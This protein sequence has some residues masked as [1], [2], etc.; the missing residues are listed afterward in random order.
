[1]AGTGPAIDWL[2]ESVTD[3]D[4]GDVGALQRPAYR[5]GLIAIEAGEAGPE[6]LPFALGD[7]RLG[8]RIG[9][10]K[11]TAGLAARCFE[12]L[13]RFAFGFQRADLDDP[14]GVGSDRLDRAVLLNGWRLR[15]GAGSWIGV[16][17]GL[18]NGGGGRYARY[19]KYAEDTV[20]GAVVCRLGRH[21]SPGHF[22]LVGFS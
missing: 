14:S 5:F 20:P 6:Q 18:W 22:D 21:F 8:K 16:S 1:M 12:P 2:C 7:N 19:R 10:R 3:G 11:Q 15:L 13:P 9:V 4:A 17:H